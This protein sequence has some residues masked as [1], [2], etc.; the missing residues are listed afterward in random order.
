MERISK[1]LPDM[2][3]F[4]TIAQELA[5]AFVEAQNE[6]MKEEADASSRQPTYW[7]AFEESLDKMVKQ[8]TIDE[9]SST[10]TSFSLD[11]LRSLLSRLESWN[12]RSVKATLGT[13]QVLATE[14]EE[15]LEEAR[16]I[17]QRVEL[18]VE[19][20]TKLR[21]LHKVGESFANK[22]RAKL[23][24]KGKEKVPLRVL[25][26][27]MKE[28]EALPI[29]TEEVRFFRNQRGR[30]QA[31]CHSAQKASRDKSLEKS[32]D[33][34][35]EAA[36]IR[37][38]LPDLEFV[39]AQVSMAEWVQKAM[40][41]TDKRSSVPLAT[42]EQLFEDPS[43]ALIK[44]EDCEV[45]QVLLKAMNEGRDWQ[46]RANKM[47]G[48]IPTP[49]SRNSKRMPTA[50]ELQTMLDEHN[51][52]NKVCV[53]TVS[54]HI[55]GI[56]RRAKAWMKKQERTLS[57][58]WSL[59][60]AKSLLEEGKQL[61]VQ[62]DLNPQFS[63]LVR[64][65]TKAEDWC[66]RARTMLT[67]LALTE[68]EQL[69][70][71]VNSSFKAPQ[72]SAMDTGTVSGEETDGPLTKKVR[73]SME[74]M[75]TSEFESRLSLSG[76]ELQALKNYES[77]LADLSATVTKVESWLV[78]LLSSDKLPKQQELLALKAS[79]G[80]VRDP[81]LEEDINQLC[82]GAV[83]WHDRAESV[84]S[85]PFPRPAGV[86]RSL[87][88]LIHDLTVNPMRY[89]H[90]KE[91]FE[92]AKMEVWA[93]RVRYVTLPMSESALDE[94]VSTC[95]FDSEFSKE[96][97]E[98]QSAGLA[99]AREVETQVASR[100][101]TW[102]ED[103]MRQVLGLARREGADLKHG[104][105][106]IAVRYAQAIRQIYVKVCEDLLT[107][108]RT[109]MHT[110]AEAEEFLGAL[111]SA[112]LVGSNSLITR[113]EIALNRNEALETNSKRLGERL[114]A[115]YEAGKA[116]VPSTESDLFHEL[117]G[118]LE[119]VECAEIK[120]EHF[121]S[122][123]TPIVGRLLQY[124]ATVR[125]LFKWD[126][127]EVVTEAGFRPP[128][129]EVEK[130]WSSIC[131]EAESEFKLSQ[132]FMRDVAYLASAFKALQ[133]AR[134]WRKVFKE[135]VAG[136]RHWDSSR[137]RMS[138][139]ALKKH[140]TVWPSLLIMAP[141]ADILSNEKMADIDHW[142]K[143]LNTVVNNR[144]KQRQRC[145]L[146]EAENLLKSAPSPM[147]VNSL[148]FEVLAG[149]VS[150]AQ[151]MRAESTACVVRSFT[152]RTQPDGGEAFDEIR[153]TELTQIL[154]ETRKNI[155]EIGTEELLE[156][157]LRLRAIERNLRAILARPQVVP[158]ELVD[159][160]L[161][162]VA[163]WEEQTK[164]TIGSA[165]DHLQGVT[166]KVSQ[167]LKYVC[168]TKVINTRKWNR[169]ASE[170]L[171]QLPVQHQHA[172]LPTVSGTA[173]SRKAAAV[174]TSGTSTPTNSDQAMA[175]TESLITAALGAPP[176]AAG[177]KIL[178][179]VMRNIEKDMPELEHFEVHKNPVPEY[180][181]PLPLYQLP[182]SAPSTPNPAPVVP[183]ATRK[184][185]KA[186][187]AQAVAVPPEN[188]LLIKG[189]SPMHQL[190]YQVPW[191]RPGLGY[192]SPLNEVMMKKPPEWVA[193]ER[194]RFRERIAKPGLTLM[195]A[196]E[197]LM[198]HK[199]GPL[200]QTIEYVRMRNMA[201]VALRTF[202]TSTNRF[203]FLWP[204]NKH[205]EAD[206][207]MEIWERVLQPSG[208]SEL[209]EGSTATA[210]AP[211]E[212]EEVELVGILLQMDGLAF[213]IPA[214]YRLLMLML[215]MYDWRVRSQSVCHHMTR[216]DR[217]RPWAG[218]DRTLAHWASTPP[219]SEIF[220]QQPVPA[221]NPSS[222]SLCI[223][224]V[225]APPPRAYVLCPMHMSFYYVIE[226]CRHFIRV[227]S[228]MCELCY[229]VTT[230]D[231]EDVFWI[232]CDVCDHWYHGKCA[233]VSQSVTSF[234]CPKCVL[235]S[236]T[237]SADRKRVAA[238][239]LESLPP[240]RHQPIAASTR[241]EEATTLLNEAKLQQ[242]IVTCNPV[243]VGIFKRIANPQS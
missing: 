151:E 58:T 209:D 174:T 161:K 183:P 30:I 82:D 31:L 234:T 225:P 111:R 2:G 8:E 9:G 54:A 130:L 57:G 139:A 243:E 167:G 214:K 180:V 179:I 86:L 188:P 204:R 112:K 135:I 105:E 75:D 215:D 40:A 38:I 123:F 10:S 232:S 163:E 239:L 110:R 142:A 198:E 121:D 175:Q 72:N 152:Y 115:D 212:S 213:Q 136:L 153:T 233:G 45:M 186:A 194:D 131:G 37:A 192:L 16:I 118:L 12:E 137:D 148:E 199:R 219:A 92:A 124:Q 4:N 141:Y 201:A 95:P 84:L 32:K 19:V 90:W 27:F 13:G 133:D 162:H 73:R 177:E 193:A 83:K 99:K 76:K 28:A 138:L 166:F 228:D 59:L 160:Y 168:E 200:L 79:L 210:N 227:M 17:G 20:L 156:I 47:L 39:K 172:G 173:A 85:V 49:E 146:V 103:W 81:M 77:S 63:D 221:V 52:L 88:T 149:Q 53:P 145:S 106:M 14:V 231:Q 217:P 69:E 176:T 21:I 97:S 222:D 226:S 220:S 5:I 120:V 182:A 126:H 100:L 207:A 71:L 178:D 33:V 154:R 216:F 114:L 223:H 157:E 46:N 117:L 91:A 66:G 67:S 158:V 70:P 25:T 170:F 240:R 190:L 23:T 26:D 187:T 155:I 50:D 189:L 242:I 18:P 74:A 203:P 140:V 65:V 24:L 60:D 229:S 6:V 181:Y 237:M 211:K 218:D 236:S 150:V 197:L 113:V 68:I 104:D 101:D 165:A 206:V 98:L 169:M 132:N 127:D 109:P 55:E 208:S 7:D 1:T 108:R 143:D 61:S 56:L 35:V 238:Q 116:S 147:C 11:A 44:P 185:G 241:T 196:L 89:E 15:L 51:K 41:K 107:P 125:G 122:H 159:A 22:V 144:A 230:T 94:L 34:T 184:G 202:K 29:E 78:P 64:E 171:A 42:I 164:E 235:A 93:H 129:D 102:Q 191:T 87:A 96:L 224:V 195:S 80:I 48:G 3:P 62:V 119:S 134:E 43:A 205:E 36:E 128:L